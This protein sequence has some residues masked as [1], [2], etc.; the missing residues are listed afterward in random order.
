MSTVLS[1]YLELIRTSLRLDVSEEKEVI[2]E[3]ETYIEDRLEELAEDG[4]SEE[5]AAKTCV[6]LLERRL[7]SGGQ[8][9]E[10]I[11]RA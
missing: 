4:L 1:H 7:R 8:S 6:G 9:S 2:S 11:Y 3:L 5:E 10:A